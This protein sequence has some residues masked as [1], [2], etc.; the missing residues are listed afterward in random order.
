MRLGRFGELDPTYGRIPIS[1]SVLKRMSGILYMMGDSAARV[2]SLGYGDRLRTGNWPTNL[3][4]RQKQHQQSEQA[5]LEDA[6]VVT[7]DAG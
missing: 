1:T 5:A 6:N 4:D 3:S 2:R 7:G